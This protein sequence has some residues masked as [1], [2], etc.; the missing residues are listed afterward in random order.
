MADKVILID[1]GRLKFNGSF[2]TLADGGDLETRF[3]EMTGGASA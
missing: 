2:D 1:E 3:K